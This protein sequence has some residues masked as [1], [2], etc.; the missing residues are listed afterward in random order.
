MTPMLTV[1]VDAEQRDRLRAIA[2]AQGKTEAELVR[3]MLDRELA[4]GPLA[5]RVAGVKGAIS[6]PRRPADPWRRQIKS[7][8]WRS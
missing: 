6:L 7:R 2:A 1:R 5:S 3:A 4:G 8:N